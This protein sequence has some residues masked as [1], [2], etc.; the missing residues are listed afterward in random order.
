MVKI[1]LMLPDDLG[2]KAQAHAMRAGHPSIEDY[3]RALIREDVDREISS[4]LE[5]ALLE[6]LDSPAEEMT[7]AH[8]AKMRADLISQHGGNR[9]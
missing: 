9:S 5:S 2:K 6:G 3:V 7:A 8:W 1:N 4:E